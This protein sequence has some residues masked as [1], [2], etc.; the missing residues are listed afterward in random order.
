MQTGLQSQSL[1]KSGL[2]RLD[3]LTALEYQIYS[4]GN[5][6]IPS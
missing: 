5:V 6:A 4:G 1:R 2:C 3:A